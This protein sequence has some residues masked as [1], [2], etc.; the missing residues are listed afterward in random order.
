[1]S[2]SKKDFI[3]LADLIRFYN[4]NNTPEEQFTSRQIEELVGFCKS[5]NYRFK[6]ELWIAYLKGECG[7]GG[8]KVKNII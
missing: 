5:Q 4:K 2:M 3:E 7:P 6:H 8:G 1:M